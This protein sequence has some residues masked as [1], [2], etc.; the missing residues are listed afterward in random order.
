[1]R[2]S[3]PE[4]ALFCYFSQ[5]NAPLA[6]QK[7]IRAMAKRYTWRG[8][9][10]SG[11]GGVAT[12]P[13][14]SIAIDRLRANLHRAVPLAELAAEAGVSPRRL[15]EHFQNFIGVPPSTY[16][17]R[18]RLNAVRQQLQQLFNTDPIAE[19]ALRHGFPH[20]G[21]FGQQY[22]RL[23]GETAS[24]TRQKVFTYVA[25]PAP[26]D[27]QPEIAIPPFES[28]P[29]LAGLAGWLRDAIGAALCGDATIR[30][31]GYAPGPSRDVTSP[32]LIRG[33]LQEARDRFRVR[34]ALVDAAQHRHL[35]GD[36]WEG[37]IASPFPAL[38]RIVTVVIG[39]VLPNIRKAEITRAVAMRPEDLGLYQLCLRA[40]PLLAANTPGNTRHALDLLYRAIERHPDYG[41]ASALAGWG[42]AQ[43]V[44]Q[45]GST[46]PVEDR[47][48]ALLLA[49]RAATL[50][51]DDAMVLT[52]RS[53]VHTMAEQRDIA[54][55]LVV[56][57]LARNPQLAWAWERSGWCQS[58]SG[59]PRAAI[60]GFGRS[61]R[62]DPAT[63][64]KATLFAG[65]GGGFFAQGRYDLAARW[66]RRTL[67]A[68]P[69]AMWINRALAVA[70]ARLGEQHEAHRS[71]EALRRYR[72]DIT[73]GNVVS[74]MHF[75]T[76]FVSRLAN[77]L[78]DLGLPP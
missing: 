54:G 64:A 25:S 4:R 76:D 70:Y 65:I 67:D 68:E 6:E 33:R 66:M 30:L 40:L 44:Q 14:V 75:P 69:G 36:A 60:A 42:Y 55:E 31:P 13:D 77:G 51:P 19:I 10:R 46:N 2:G 45:V 29:V 53:A 3:Y 23:F 58:Y 61:L 57:A 9:P 32:Y 39:A 7:D 52:A 78:N 20:P 12:L 15:Q 43:L 28:P 34:L 59:N 63:P 18:L 74:V 62:L 72:P 49:Q 24:E 27:D 35:W 11:D 41:L 71:L 5:K 50:D 56:R 37:S 73:V 8:R 48:Q 26:R 16:G 47:A 21:R 17:Q 1:L 38:D 22:R